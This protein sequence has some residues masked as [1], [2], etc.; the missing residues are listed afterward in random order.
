[1]LFRLMLQS[2]TEPND[3]TFL[4][5]LPTCDHLGALD[6]DKWIHAYI[7]KNFQS[8]TNTSLWTSLIGTYAKCKN[9][10]AAK[11]VFNG[12]EAK[13]WLLKMGCACNP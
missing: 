8:F 11:K 5:I 10:E 4:G 6:L 2:N 3:V 9:I 1:M 12:M 7:D 13:A